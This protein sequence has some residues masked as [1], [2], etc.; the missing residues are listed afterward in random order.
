MAVSI[1][2]N[3]V[4]VR[5]SAVDAKLSGALPQTI[6]EVSLKCH[7]DA[8]LFVWRLMMDWETP[9]ELALA[10]ESAGLRNGLDE[11]SDFAIVRPAMPDSYPQWLEVGRIGAYSACW[12]KGMEPGDV[13][14]F[15]PK[16]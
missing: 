13:V 12:L 2:F 8:H 4:V 1:K 5:K 9:M 7:E 6:R 14:G 16:R 3:N 11:D 10:L 15:F